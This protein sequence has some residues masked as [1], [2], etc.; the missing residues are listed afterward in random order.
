LPDNATKK[1]SPSAAY[2]MDYLKR[3]RAKVRPEIRTWLDGFGLLFA[4]TLFFA[5]SNRP[6]TAS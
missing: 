3:F 5:L 4:I 1:S 6:T 2:R